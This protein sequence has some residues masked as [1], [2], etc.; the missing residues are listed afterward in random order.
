MQARSWALTETLP[1]QPV[2]L[3][4]SGTTDHGQFARLNCRRR[5]LR[6]AKPIR[7]RVL[8]FCTVEI[9]GSANTTPVGGRPLLR[10]LCEPLKRPKVL[11]CPI[12]TVGQIRL[13]S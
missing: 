4:C 10:R 8:A 12:Q 1:C 2:V 9:I 13:W 7:L 11:T 6:Y 5:Q 3:S